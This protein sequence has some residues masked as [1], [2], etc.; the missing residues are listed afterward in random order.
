M[1]E[2][3][4]FDETRPNVSG[5][6]RFKF[7]PDTEEGL[8][9]VRRLFGKTRER[10]VYA[11]KLPDIRKRNVNE[12]FANMSRSLVVPAPYFSSVRKILG[13][14]RRRSYDSRPLAVND[15]TARFIF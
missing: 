9:G 12:K 11:K 14:L 7:R 6:T 5:T 4:P 15:T 8:G 2:T 10:V 13:C 1:Y 3:D